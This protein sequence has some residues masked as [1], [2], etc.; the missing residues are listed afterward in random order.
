MRSRARNAIH[1]VVIWT[2]KSF[3]Y[4]FLCR[5]VSGGG[6]IYTI[7]RKF[8]QNKKKRT[9]VEA[10]TESSSIESPLL[11]PQ[12]IH[13]QR[14]TGG[15][16]VYQKQMRM[17][18]KAVQTIQAPVADLCGLKS[19]D[20]PESNS[21][22]HY[23][24][25]MNSCGIML[26]AMIENMKLYYLVSS[27]MYEGHMTDYILRAEIQNIWDSCLKD[28]LSESNLTGG[29][30][31][32]IVNFKLNICESVPEGLVNGDPSVL[33]KAFG[34][35]INNALRFT[36]DGSIDVNISVTEG[37]SDNVLLHAMVKDTGLG[38]PQPSTTYIFDP[39]VKAHKDT[40][41]GGIGMGLSLSRAMA[42]HAGGETILESTGDTGSTFHSYFPI[43]LL[44][45]HRSSSVRKPLELCIVIEYIDG[46]GNASI[47]GIEQR[48]NRRS[49]NYSSSSDNPDASPRIKVLVVDDI[50]LN[51]NIVKKILNRFD[52]DVEDASNGQVAVEMCRVVEYDIIL[53]DIHM[54]VLNGL[55]ASKMIRSDRDSKNKSTPI[56][57]LSGDRPGEIYQ[58]CQDV[59][60]NNCLMKPVQTRSLI[61]MIA[62]YVP[63]SHRS[64]LSEKLR[65]MT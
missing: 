49:L 51:L 3:L 16:R 47:G 43:T 26:A 58:I 61:E 11:N 62:T 28:H 10:S 38:I 2:N 22:Y 52:A 7:M 39:L 46:I 14:E 65:K 1:R 35:L 30:K 41:P 17:M 60:I 50:K 25:V 59:G 29:Q 48:N 57:A 8:I 24:R 13:A 53:M 42:E 45:S 63:I 64:S 37:S 4:C 12:L 19:V 55:D 36:S 20:I 27:G 44:R 33:V 18:M 5:E 31:E 32:G 9:P 40:V 6:S 34:G 56:I 21:I 23:A 54:P 15:K